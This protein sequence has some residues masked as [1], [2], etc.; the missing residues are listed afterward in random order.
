MSAALI[1]LHLFILLYPDGMQKN[2]EKLRCIF[3]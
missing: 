2:L 1:F 3:C